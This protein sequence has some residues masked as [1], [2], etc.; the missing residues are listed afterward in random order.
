ML[1]VS[2][3]N[4][5][6][7]PSDIVSQIKYVKR[8]LNLNEI[9]TFIANGHSL[10]A[11]FKHY[12]DGYVIQKYRNYENFS[13]TCFVFFDLD[14]DFDLSLKEVNDSLTLKPTL[15]YTTYRHIVEGNRYRLLYIFEE[16]ITEIET[17][18][19]IYYKIM[20]I[21]NFSKLEDNCGCNC[22]QNVFGSNYNLKG[23]TYINNNI[24]YHVK[25]FLD[26]KDIT[27]HSKRE[28][29]IIDC[30]VL[31]EGC[32]SKRE[33]IITNDSFLSDFHKMNLSD[34]LDK[35]RYPIIDETPMEDVDEDTAYMPYPKDY[36]C[37]RRRW[38]YYQCLDSNGKEKARTTRIRR[39]KDGEG[40]RR[41]LF[42]NGIIRRLVTNDTITYDNLLYCLVYEFEHFYEYK[43]IGKSDIK[44]VADSAW[45]ADLTKYQGLR[46]A[47]NGFR[48]NPKFCLKYRLTPKQAKPIAQKQFNCHK[49]GELYDCSLSDAA[50]VEA[51]KELGIDICVK[52]LQRWR[53]GNG[54]TKYNKKPK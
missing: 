10:S 51:F 47:K 13:D 2:V 20:S 36:V 37:I 52:T 31:F 43:D 54:I 21:N 25:D 26:E 6:T 7:K 27:L 23:Y 5:K 40:R 22:V 18:K 11:N 14:N 53:K 45:N 46:G 19:V 39:I 17:Y 29:S 28:E 12:Q 4:Y 41:L 38:T 1:S 16:P 35:Y 9:E 49:I 44:K 8:D 42:M 24:T 32:K 15:C 48:V 30:N 33:Y 34:L 50:N 3:E